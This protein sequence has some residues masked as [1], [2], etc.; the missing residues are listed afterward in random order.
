L[1]LSFSIPLIG[2]PT[3]RSPRPALASGRWTGIIAPELA[4]AA[5]MFA[6]MS[7]LSNARARMS[8]KKLCTTASLRGRQIFE[9]LKDRFSRLVFRKLH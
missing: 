1:R 9:A 6:W 8:N 5:E 2:R 4:R 3:D 7:F